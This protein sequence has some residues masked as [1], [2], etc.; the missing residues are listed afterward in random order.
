MILKGAILRI[1]TVRGL[2]ASGNSI[3]QHEQKDYLLPLSM[4]EPL[5]GDLVKEPP[6]K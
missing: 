5:P 1:P 2:G 3:L 4:E 6:L